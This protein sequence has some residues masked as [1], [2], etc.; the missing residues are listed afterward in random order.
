MGRIVQVTVGKANPNNMNGVSRS[1][2]CLADNLQRKGFAAEVWGITPSP[3]DPTPERPY[4]LSLFQLRKSRFLLDASLLKAAK[5]LGPDDVLHFHGCLIPEFSAIAR[6]AKARGARWIVSPRGGLMDRALKRNATAKALY[7]NLFEKSFLDDAAAIHV[8]CRPEA[9]EV[10]RHFKHDRLLE[11]PN[12]VN[13]AD[14]DPL[15]P[16]KRVAHSKGAPVAGFV[17]R[18]DVEQKGLDLLLEG[19]ALHAQ[20]GGATRLEL[21]GDGPD[22]KSLEALVERL[23]LSQ[24]VKFHGELRGKDKFAFLDRVDYFVHTS[25]WEGMPNAV[26]EALAVGKPVLVSEQTNMGD[27]VEDNSAGLCLKENVPAEIALGFDRFEDWA[28]AGA[29]AQRGAAGKRLIVDRFDWSHVADRF[30]SDAYQ[31][32]AR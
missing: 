6:I 14:I 15:L 3:S 5:T 9:I 23:G 31:G 12:G 19:L 10:S 13:F 7:L 29:L 20:R 17:G 22:R 32:A 2:H 21:V 27:L 25:R 28:K 30:V 1:V 26:L 24:R 18:L 8:L 4:S 16:L 11:I